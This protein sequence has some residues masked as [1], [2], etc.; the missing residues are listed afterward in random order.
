MATQPLVH[1]TETVRKGRKLARLVRTPAYR[2]AL[3]YRVAAAVEHEAD[4]FEA[5][6]RTVVDVGA[7]R[8][9]FAVFASERFPRADILCFEPLP[10]AI[11]DLRRIA[12]AFPAIRVFPVALSS[13]PGVRDMHVAASDDSSSLLP[14]TSRQTAEFPGTEA[15]GT[16]PVETQRL[17]SALRDV[18][19]REPALLK[20]DV[21][22]AELEVL[23][24]ATGLLPAF[25]AV[26]VECSFVELYEGQ[27]LAPEVIA[28]LQTAG[29]DLTDIGPVSRDAHGRC[30][31][32]D[33]LFRPRV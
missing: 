11:A 30:L 33:L 29:L 25:A 24:G 8:G 31:Q 1:V 32:A 6:F 2:R 5:D 22:G 27:A 19:I 9:Q 28:E 7:N 10:A 15:V 13:G 17:D 12:A 20:I 3:R 26:L 16:V 23:R 14:I 4:V 21:Q 18:E